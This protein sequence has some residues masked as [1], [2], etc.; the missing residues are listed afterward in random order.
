MKITWNLRMLCAQK[1]IWTGAD[2]GR[3]LRSALGLSV[4]SQTLS[5]LLTRQ[6]KN[7]S[8]NMLLALCATLDCAPNDLLVVDVSPTRRTGREL[9]DTIMRV[10]TARA[11]KRVRGGRRRRPAAP[12]ATRI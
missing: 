8:L 3:H 6:P 1:G 11:P 2:L 5:T 9:V 12:P 10:N 7:L 4:S